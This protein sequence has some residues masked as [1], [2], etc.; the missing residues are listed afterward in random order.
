M[1]RVGVCSLRVDVCPLNLVRH[2]TIF[3]LPRRAQITRG[4]LVS[5]HA[6]TV[7]I[8]STALFSAEG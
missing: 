1:F 7:S 6:Q 5:S 8:E 4:A 2:F 3:L